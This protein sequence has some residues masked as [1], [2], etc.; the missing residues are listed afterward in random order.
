MKSGETVLLFV[1]DDNKQPLTSF[2]TVWRRFQIKKKEKEN[3]NIWNTQR[4]SR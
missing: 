4:N 1:C 2:Q 3:W